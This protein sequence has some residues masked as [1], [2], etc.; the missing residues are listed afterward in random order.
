MSRSSCS[1]RSR[2]PEWRPVPG[3]RRYDV[4]D[5][6]LVREA[7]TGRVLKQTASGRNS[8][9][10]FHMSVSIVGDDGVRRNLFVHRIVLLAHVGP[11]PD[12]VHACHVNDDPA[13]N[14]LSNL[15]WGRPEH[16]RAD[17]RRNG[18]GDKTRAAEIER[19]RQSSLARLRAE[20]EV[21]RARFVG[22]GP[23]RPNAATAG[24]P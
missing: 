8:G 7:S 10:L 14:R 24:A 17:Q 1:S 13:D 18:G 11:A 19:S 5:S 16:N 3:A 20:I 21:E 6:G 22:D 4:S 12:G 2:R 9:R 15:Y 23:A